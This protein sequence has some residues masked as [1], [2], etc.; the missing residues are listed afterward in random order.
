MSIVA[1]PDVPL[2]LVNTTPAVTEHHLEVFF[3]F[4]VSVAS[5][6]IPLSA[7]LCGIEHFFSSVAI[8]DAVA[9]KL[10]L[11]SV[12]SPGVISQLTRIPAA[13]L[14]PRSCHV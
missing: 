1:N 2:C 6:A 9:F 5:G 12:R 7:A 10:L 14:D 4:V 13:G 3:G 8:S 11:D